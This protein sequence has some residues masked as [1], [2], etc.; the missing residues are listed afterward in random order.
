M[1]SLMRKLMHRETPVTST[2]RG[3][4]NCDPLG[5]IIFE[6]PNIGVL[7]AGIGL[8]ASGNRSRDLPEPGK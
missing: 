4:V 1:I 6:A 3:R 5:E 8:N 7:G 2:R